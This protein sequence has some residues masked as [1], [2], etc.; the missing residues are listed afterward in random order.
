MIDLGFLDSWEGGYDANINSW[1]IF[2]L[3]HKQ[4]ER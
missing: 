4:K 1:H 2:R 3:C